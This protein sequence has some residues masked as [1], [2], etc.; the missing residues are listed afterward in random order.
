MLLNNHQS[1]D[2]IKQKIDE[3][4]DYD[5][6]DA[7]ADNNEKNN[8][9]NDSDSADSDSDSDSSDSSIISDNEIFNITYLVNQIKLNSH[10]FDTITMDWVCIN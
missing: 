10:E 4:Y 6:G 1:N 8:S 7:D 5:D 3:N 9:E 2:K